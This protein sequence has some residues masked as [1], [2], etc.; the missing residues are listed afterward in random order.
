MTTIPCTIRTWRVHIVSLLL[1]LV[2]LLAPLAVPLIR[3]YAFR[4]NEA[5]I[6][7]TAFALAALIMIIAISMS[8]GLAIVFGPESVSFRP[9]LRRPTDLL[10]TDITEVSLDLEFD[11]LKP[12]TRLTLWGR[13]D[14][15]ELLRIDISALPRPEQT[16]VLQILHEKIPGLIL[17]GHAR[18]LLTG[19]PANLDQRFQRMSFAMGVTG[20]VLLLL[21]L[22]HLLLRR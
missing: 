16:T 10:Y 20:C 14:G 18:E 1:T 22:A 19:T 11:G 3:G 17:A 4:P 15:R 13:P 21:K 7:V 9:T 2:M 12:V 6:F 8:M 5:V